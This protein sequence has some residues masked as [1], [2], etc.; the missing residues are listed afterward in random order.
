MKIGI[1]TL[2]FNNNYGGYLQSY[3]LMTVLKDEGHIVELI[4][5]RH[6]R[7]PLSVRV[8]YFIKSLIK[9]MLGR[10]HFSIFMDQECDLRRRGINMM[11][12]VDSKIFPKT[13]PL[14]STK[15]L[16]QE[17]SNKYDVVIV[18]SDQVWRP[19]YV[20]NVENF[21]FDFVKLSTTRRI[22]YAAS[23][24]E[25]HPIYT[26]DQ[27]KECGNLIRNFDFIG[28]REDSG[29]EIIKEFEWKVNCSTKVVLDPTMLL[30]KRHYESLF[31]P[32]KNVTRYLLTYILDESKDADHIVSTATSILNLPEKRII[33]STAWQ[34]PEYKMPSIESWLAGIRYADFV[35]TDSFH[36][37]VFCIIFN[38]PFIVY[39]NSNRGADRFYSLLRRFGLESRIVNSKNSCLSAI[40]EQIDWK[41]VDIILNQEVQSSMH[42]L[43]KSICDK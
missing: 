13:R 28:L 22:A 21:F 8:K 27:I 39:V 3:A 36:G 26:D 1:L 40:T 33:D 42:L 18:G 43:L 37:T 20:P 7:R 34:Q 23:F 19:E 32:T 30:P 35:I 38:V 14:Y 6:N 2:P 29:V 15:E 16:I 24:G 5:R 4:Y 17:C 9:I 11:S 41:R 31:P 10:P 12:F 25:R